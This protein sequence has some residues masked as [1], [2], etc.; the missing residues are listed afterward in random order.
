MIRNRAA[1]QS[2]NQVHHRPSDPTHETQDTGPLSKTEQVDDWLEH[3][4]H[5]LA[6][7]LE[8]QQEKKMRKGIRER[9]VNETKRLKK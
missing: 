2:V 7:H 1:T 3:Q 4:Q 6:K 9:K 5:A 8:E